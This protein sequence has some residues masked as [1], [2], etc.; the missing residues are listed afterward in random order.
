MLPPPWISERI[1]VDPQTVLNRVAPAMFGAGVEDVNH[2]VYGGLYA[3]R[4]FGESFEEPVP[5]TDPA[6]WRS[7]G[8]RWGAD[9]TGLHVR[10]G[11]GPKLVLQ[12]SDLADGTVEASL[13]V[14]NDQ[15]ENAGLLVRVANPG[16]GADA[17]DGYEISLSGKRRQL[18]LGKHRQNFRSLQTADA[19]VVPGRWHRL[20]VTLGG[21]RIRVFLDGEAS[22]RLDF[23]DAEGPLTSGKVALRTWHADASFRDLRLNG[24]AVPLGFATGGISGM[25]DAVRTGGAASHFALEERAFNGAL[26]QKIVHAGG[27]GQVGV[28]NRGLNR[29]GIAVRQG[30]T[31]EGRVY[32]RGQDLTGP[33]TVA[34]QSAD[35]HRTYATQRLNV[36]RDWAKAPFRLRPNATDPNA[37][38]AVWLDRPGTVWV[39]QAVLQDGRANRYRGL[40]IRADIARELIGSGVTFLRYGGTMINVPGYRWKN[41]IG[42]PD[43]R[44]PYAGH[45]YPNATNGFGIFDFLRFCESARVGASF[46][47]NVEETPEDAA[48]LAD[49]LTAPTTTPWGRR[50]AAD[51]HPAPY[52]V[53][54]IEIGNEEGIGNPDPAAMAYYAARFRLLARAIHARNPKLRLVCGAWWVP[55]APQM[56][57]VFDAIDGVAAAW[58]FHF[59]SDAPDAGTGIDRE[60]ARARRLFASWNPRTTLKAV[61][62]EENGNR[63]DLQRALGHATTLNATRRHGDFVLVDCAANALQP[64]RQNDNG[65]DQGGV[66]FT[67]DR[68]WSMPPA[69]ARRMLAKDHLPLRVA[70]RTEGGLDVLATRSEDARTLALTVVNPSARPVAS[71]IAL[72]AWTPR[73]AEAWTLAG[74]LAATNPPTGGKVISPKRIQLNRAGGEVLATLPAYSV[75]T[76]RLTR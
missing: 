62:F 46:A 37:R 27:D 60:L 15:G 71:R 51:G 52:R 48:D 5:D 61:V 14:S 7:Y 26:C 34:L 67:P 16:V 38:F 31:M 17:F 54:F 1:V 76:I 35:G 53:D 57:T 59:W 2:E 12:D 13:V 55:D 43:R 32:L 64:W 70:A 3:Q 40:P 23:T 65:W 56:K 24:R 73:K 33:V 63:H 72:T 8:G 30:Q 21:P 10:G 50:R 49:Y 28:A 44:P 39:D 69:D 6:G 36:G 18:I 9:G 25:W 29:W 45:W 22:P 11:P 58:D 75:T 19:P 4:I 47:I 68:A 41:M 74:D 66:F 20:R 42:D